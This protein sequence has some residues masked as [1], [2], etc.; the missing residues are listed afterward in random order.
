[1]T[2]SKETL[3]VILFVDDEAD[4][5]KYFQRAIG[6]L[7]AVATA[8]SVEEGK[9]VLDKHAESLLVLVSDQRMPGEYGN[10]LLRYARERH[11]HVVRILTTAYS[12]IDRTTEAINDGQ[13]YRY[14][15]KPWDIGLLRIELKQAIDF[16]ALYRE[17]DQL[18]REKMIVR[19]AQIVANRI[20]AL[21]AICTSVTGPGHFGPV[22]TYLAAAREAG[23]KVHQPD[24]S[25][26]DYSDLVGAEAIRSGEFG[27]AIRGK[28]AWF[29]QRYKDCPV[30]AA[31]EVLSEAL[32]EKIRSSGQNTLVFPD[33]RY[34]A[35]FLETQANEAI[36]M[37]H[38]VWLAFLI[39]LDGIGGAILLAR[40]ESGLQ[41]RIVKQDATSVPPR[42]AAWIEQFG[43]D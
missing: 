43:P 31:A 17:R 25:L 26:M 27:Y 10:E 15:R 32:G 33:E 7:A 41:C 38:A 5:A 9:I 12:E 20:G 23:V 14:I 8:G 4:T 11:P 35:E 30:E 40:T 16:A 22:K 1:M 39:W 28:L 6:S 34:L 42:L 19:Q 3:P 24:W 21:H 29:E 36:S 37:Q 18:L 2:D 13:I